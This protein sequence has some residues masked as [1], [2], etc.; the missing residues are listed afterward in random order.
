MWSVGSLVLKPVVGAT[1]VQILTV[2][3]IHIIFRGVTLISQGTKTVAVT[4]VLTVGVTNVASVMT[5]MMAS[6][7]ADVV[8]VVAT[9]VVAAAGRTVVDA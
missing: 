6:V 8:I 5:A 2:H 3:L 7:P 9:G 1:V 4:V